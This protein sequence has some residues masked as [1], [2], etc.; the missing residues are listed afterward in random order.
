[1]MMSETVHS[2]EILNEEAVHPLVE[3]IRTL[4]LHDFLEQP[5]LL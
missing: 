4:P 1:M 2:D 3:A 5:R